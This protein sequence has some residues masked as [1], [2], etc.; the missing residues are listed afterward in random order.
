MIFA[1]K[2]FNEETTSQN[3]EKICYSKVEDIAIYL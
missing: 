3:Y 1:L 2:F